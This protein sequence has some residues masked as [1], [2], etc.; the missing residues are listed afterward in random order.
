MKKHSHCRGIIQSDHDESSLDYGRSIDL[1][2]NTPIRNNFQHDLN[3]IQKYP[4]KYATSDQNDDDK[5]NHFDKKNYYFNN[6]DNCVTQTSDDGEGKNSKD[7]DLVSTQIITQSNENS[8]ECFGSNTELST[9]H[10]S[11]NQKIIACN[12]SVLGYTAFGAYCRRCNIPIGST[13][14]SHEDLY[15]HN[16]KRQCLQN[17]NISDLVSIINTQIVEINEEKRHTFI[18]KFD[19][20]RWTCS[21]CQYHSDRKANIT[22]HIKNKC[23]HALNFENTYY[24]TTCARYIPKSMMISHTQNHISEEVPPL[25]AG[26]IIESE[27]IIRRLFH[28]LHDESTDFEIY[29]DYL[30]TWYIQ[31]HSQD[32]FMDMMIKHCMYLNDDIDE[33]TEKDLSLIL[34]SANTW[35]FQLSDFYIN[36]LDACLRSKIQS[37]EA[38]ISS[39]ETSS[40]L[41]FNGRFHK[42]T[43]WKELQKMICIFWRCTEDRYVYSNHIIIMFVIN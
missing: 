13:P 6:D 40:K 5:E 8:N 2:N 15:M 9:T 29:I 37:F 17:Q 3:I 19:I 11:T 14:L 16:K 42:D 23:Y 30:R 10:E 36:Q 21:Q 35:L 24:K 33:E 27:N 20:I 18:I 41:C 26:T 32:L 43:V 28:S 39:E 7:D 34:K 25:P 31:S 1:Y 38:S 22:C 4:S 12:N